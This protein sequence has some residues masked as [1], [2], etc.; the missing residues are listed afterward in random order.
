M[1][2]MSVGFH[3]LSLLEDLLVDSLFYLLSWPRVGEEQSVNTGE[4]HRLLLGIFLQQF[5]G[6]VPCLILPPQLPKVVDLQGFGK[7]PGR[8]TSQK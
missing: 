6:Q 4:V 3:T 8:E 7:R 2:K 1:V 5:A